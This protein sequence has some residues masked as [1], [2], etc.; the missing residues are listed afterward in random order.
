MKTV[1]FMPLG[2]LTSQQLLEIYRH[3][4][5]KCAGVWNE[6]RGI[7]DPYHADFQVVLDWTS[8]PVD[9]DRAIYLGMEN[10][11]YGDFH[12]LRDVEAFRVA[13]FAFGEGWFPVDWAQWIGM[14]YD[15]LVYLSYPPKM[16]RVSA[17][18]SGKRF[19]PGHH[20]R[21]KWIS[22]FHAAYP[23][24]AVY[25]R[26]DL[27][28][29]CGPIP[30]KRGA[31]EDFRFSIAFENAQFDNYFTEKLTDVLLLWG[32]PIYWGAPNIADFF[33]EDA[34]VLA[35]SVEEAVEVIRQ[36]PTQRQMN[37]LAEARDLILNKYN[38]WPMLDT[39]IR[40][41]NLSWGTTL[42]EDISCFPTT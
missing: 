12:P 32:I 18:V 13:H 4:T 36:P 6:L 27:P 15:D 14:N 33:P 21:L 3:Q 9:P 24:L 29:S 37:A 23:C 16:R 11:A 34:I 31:L 7:S 30:L 2:H 26:N 42:R 8:A 25:G 17:V 1:C 5:P 41:G 35:G 28:F 10:P 22:D 38:I 40:E 39:L 20:Y 19:M